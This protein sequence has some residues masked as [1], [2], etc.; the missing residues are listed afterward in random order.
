MFK[1]IALPAALALAL[2]GCLSD[3][4]DA[5]YRSMADAVS[6]GAVDKGWIPEWLPQGAINL[7]EVHNLDTN[8]SALA[9]DIPHGVTWLPPEHCSSVDYG[10]VAPSHFGRSWWPSSKVLAT[11]YRFFQCRP[12]GPPDFEFVA[13]STSGTRG[14]HW[15]AYAR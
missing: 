1:F 13:I 9:F 12:D 3:T 7:R 11:S 4:L 8:V 5:S 6:G 10:A 2:T 15:R 14:L